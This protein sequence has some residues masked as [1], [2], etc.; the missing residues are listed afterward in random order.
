S[1][2]GAGATR[3]RARSNRATKAI[4]LATS[5]AA[6]LSGDA[7]DD[8]ESLHAE[9]DRWAIPAVGLVL[10]LESRPNDFLGGTRQQ[11]LFRRALWSSCTAD[12]GVPLDC[13]VIHYR[14][15]RRHKAMNDN[16][17][18]DLDKLK[19]RREGKKFEAR[20]LAMKAMRDDLHDVINKYLNTTDCNDE[21][22]SG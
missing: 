11:C 15:V 4:R 2:T 7:D 19:W 12:L 20:H 5:T 1:M 8:R 17:I 13:R 18:I 10:R 21:A 22:I 16:N 3:A 6:I 9:S 14:N